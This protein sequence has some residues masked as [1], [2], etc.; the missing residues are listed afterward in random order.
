MTFRDGHEMLTKIQEGR[1]FYN[2]K[3]EEY[4][5]CYNESGSICVYH[6]D[7]KSAAI[8]K[9]VAEEYWGACLGAGGTIYDDPLCDCYTKG[10]YTNLDWCNDYYQGEWEDV[11]V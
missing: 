9:E 1:D 4:V 5:F 3:A 11:T 8:L 7:N 2:P 10:D 6:V